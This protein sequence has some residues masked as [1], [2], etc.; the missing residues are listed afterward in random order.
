[1]AEPVATVVTVLDHKVGDA[2]SW[3]KLRVTLRN[4]AEQDY[5]EPVE[6]ILVETESEERNVPGDLDS[7]LPGLRLVTTEGKS[8]FELK[9]AG[10]QAA[11]SD[12]VII[13]DADCRPAPGWW[14]AVYEHWK[15]NPQAAT[16]SG[17]TFY[18][19]TSLLSRVFAVIDRAYVDVG[20]AGIT[21]TI[22]NN[23]GGFKRQVL[24]DHPFSNEVG[25]FGS[26]PHSDRIKAA[27][28]ELRFEPK[29]IAYHAFT[30][31]DMV[32]E[33]RRHI[34]FSMTR[35][36]QLHPEARNGWMVKYP[37]L[38]MVYLVLASTWS[39]V[40]RSLKFA[41][42]YGVKWFQIPV[43]WFCSFRAHL[44]ALTGARLALT[45]GSVG[46]WKTYR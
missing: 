14:R 33:E 26:E 2:A 11:S 36:R 29:M 6:F 7:I 12:F 35:Y 8:S 3:D 44:M 10:A 37:L 41:A 17:R 16:I 20:E 25:P 40:K 1:M 9:N 15:A 43:I 13:L 19:G 24:L 30:G 27:G 22:S 28:L 32:R 42:K 23:N 34:G 5:R 38:W 4:L 39:D 45:G 46:G 21:Y 18:E 31:W